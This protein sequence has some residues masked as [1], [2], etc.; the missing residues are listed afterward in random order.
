LP[1]TLLAACALLLCLCADPH[2]EFGQTASSYGQQP[3][4]PGRCPHGARQGELMR[5]LN[6]SQ[7]VNDA[8]LQERVCGKPGCVAH[9]G[10]ASRSVPLT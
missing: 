4:Q 2:P 3:E 1:C 7:M 5:L 9:Q 6:V 10:E 8:G